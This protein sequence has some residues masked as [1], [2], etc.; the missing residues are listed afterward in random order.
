MLKEQAV[1]KGTGPC[2]RASYL[3]PLEAGYIQTKSTQAEA[4]PA[5]QPAISNADA[6]IQISGRATGTTGFSPAEQDLQ[7]VYLLDNRKALE[8]L[9]R[10][11]D[12]GSVINMLAPEQARCQLVKAVATT[13]SQ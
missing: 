7:A 8:P 12:V 13:T 2:S 6:D 1:R 10:G 9:L 11:E 4:I 5:P 3:I